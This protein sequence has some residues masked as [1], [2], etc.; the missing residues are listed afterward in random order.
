MKPTQIIAGR[1]YLACLPDQRPS[2]VIALEP[3]RS[4]L[5]HWACRDFDG[6][7]RLISAAALTAPEQQRLAA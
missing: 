6:Q 1:Q 5:D 7:R 4:V 3:S 2:L